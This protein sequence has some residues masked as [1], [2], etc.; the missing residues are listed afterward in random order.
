MEDKAQGEAHFLLLLF[1]VPAPPVLLAFPPSSMSKFHPL[2]FGLACGITWALGLILLA[3]FSLSMD[4]GTDVL[5]LLGS[6][7]KGYDASLTGAIVGA[8]WGFLDGLIGGY[9]FAWIYN[10][11][12]ERK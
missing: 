10:Y 3:F 4:W 1:R 5:L 6:A 12:Q 7:Y 2:N 11:L 8:I 9:V